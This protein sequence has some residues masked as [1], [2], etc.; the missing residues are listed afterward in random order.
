MYR[1]VEQG[2]KKAVFNIFVRRLEPARSNALRG[3]GVA[4]SC[5]PAQAFVILENVLI[6]FPRPLRERARVRGLSS[7]RS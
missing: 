3:G 1:E 7:K 4:S 2:I 5:L 6:S